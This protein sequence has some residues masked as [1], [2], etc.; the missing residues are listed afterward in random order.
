[1]TAI[2]AIFATVDTLAWHHMVQRLER[3]ARTVAATATDNGWL[4]RETP[5]HHGGWPFGAWVETDELIAIHPVSQFSTYEMQWTGTRLRLGGTWL[6]LFS[7]PTTVSVRGPQALRLVSHGAV[8]TILA[9][10][11]RIEAQRSGHIDF[12]SSQLEI[13]SSGVLPAQQIA[14]GTVSGRLL[15]FPDAAS[16]ATKLGLTAEART[17]SGFPLPNGLMT[18]LHGVRLAIALL[19]SGERTAAT[20]LD[21][22]S[23]GR[24][25]VQDA[26][27]SLGEQPRAPRISVTGAMTLPDRNGTVSL[28]IT[29]WR[30]LARNLLDRPDLESRLSPDIQTLLQGVLRKMLAAPAGRDRPIS[31]SAPVVNGHLTLNT[32]VFSVLTQGPSEAP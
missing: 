15:L 1:M 32:Q 11:L 24:L 26:S 14:L 17:L 18:D 21:A 8:L 31:L 16:G 23:Y 27:A 9:Q 22:A 30:D 7:Q 2:L 13:A 29:G 4:I 12:S 10:D 19:A 6:N 28:T 3:S 5:L 25:L 20:F